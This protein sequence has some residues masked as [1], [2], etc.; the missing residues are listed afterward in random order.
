MSD[1]THFDED[2]KAHMVNVGDKPVTDRVAVACGEIRMAA[3]TLD[4]IREGG[5]GK[6]DVL[7]VARLAGIMGAKQTANLIPLCH[8]LGLDHVAVD[9]EMDESLPGVRITGTCRVTGRTGIEME[10]MTAVSVAALTIY[11]MCKAVDR[12]MQIG[13]IRLTHKSG[14]KSGDFNAE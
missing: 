2:G 12:G 1:L 9:L 3:S 8:P 13:S 7:G 4:R 11:D 5:F 6:G 10:A 14:G